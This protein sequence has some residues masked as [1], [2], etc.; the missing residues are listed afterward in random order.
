MYVYI[1]V[2]Y[3]SYFRQKPDREG[4][5][6]FSVFCSRGGGYEDQI[7][8]THAMFLHGELGKTLTALVCARV[9]CT[10]GEGEKRRLLQAP[11]LFCMLSLM[12]C[13]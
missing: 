9:G 11:C 6:G 4:A 3:E 10:G 5:W 2:F 8:E 13:I 7:F 1:T 12:Y